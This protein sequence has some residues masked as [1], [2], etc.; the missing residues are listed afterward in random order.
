MERKSTKINT[1]V[2]I[3]VILTFDE[4]TLSTIN[5][6]GDSDP[7]HFTQWQDASEKTDGSIKPLQRNVTWQFLQVIF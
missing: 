4:D 7:T 1:K 6:T 2:V 3:L 5:K